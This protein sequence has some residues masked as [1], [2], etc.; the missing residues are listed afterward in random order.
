LLRRL[1]LIPGLLL[2]QPLV[3]QPI[4]GAQTDGLV[5]CV[6]GRLCSCSYQRASRMTGQPAAF[7]WD[8][9]LLRP[10]CGDAA[11]DPTIRSDPW[12]PP[13]SLTID[14]GTVLSPTEPG[15]PGRPWPRPDRPKPDAELPR[16]HP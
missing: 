15:I 11:A 10:S 3:A 12:F 9:G 16:A 1:L 5:A 6:A 8:C 7:R 4:C 2:S 13:P 14:T